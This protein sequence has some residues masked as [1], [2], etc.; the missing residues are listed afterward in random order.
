MALVT[1][2]TFLMIFC[3]ALLG[4]CG[5]KPPEP[6]AAAPLLRP[7]L[8]LGAPS[9]RLLV[10][11]AAL[12]ERGGIPGVLVLGAEGVARF[13]MVRTGKNVN[14]RIEILSGLRGDETLVLGDLREVRDGSIITP[15]TSAK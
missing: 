7:V 3:A 11:R 12:V 13:R 6:A 2:A 10:P 9:G 5:E 14:G 15:V 1:R 4:A 8:T